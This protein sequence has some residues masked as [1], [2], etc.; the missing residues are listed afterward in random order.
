[1]RSGAAGAL[2]AAVAVMAAPFAA[3]WFAPAALP[4]HH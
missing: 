3:T 1:M 4:A 2:V